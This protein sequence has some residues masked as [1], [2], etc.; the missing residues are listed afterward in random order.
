MAFCK[1]CG[2]DLNGARFCPNCGTAEGEMI[3]QQPHNVAPMG[4]N[5]RSNSLA[6]MENMQQYFG[7]KKP[8]YDELDALMAKIE[9]QRSKKKT[10]WLVAG[11]LMSLLTWFLISC[12]MN[13]LGIIIFGAIDLGLFYM[14]YVQRKKNNE[15]VSVLLVEQA[16][17]ATELMDYYTAYGYCPVGI[18]YTEPSILYTINDVI[19]KGRA[20]TPK[21]AI[22]ILLDDM[23][24]EKM[25]EEAKRAA[26]AAE[27][28][29]AYSRQTAMYSKECARAARKAANYVAASFWL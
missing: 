24:K 23:H 20:D 5:P 10:G 8:L 27:A 22:N 14:F 12:D 6:E 25:E 4:G 17:V 18:E 7:A 2:T 15:K 13:W 29:A 21:E 11:I 1:N 28:T 9:K 19:R 16:T 26:N 3:V